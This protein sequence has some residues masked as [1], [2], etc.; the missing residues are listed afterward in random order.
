[1]GNAK[2]TRTISTLDNGLWHLEVHKNNRFD[3]I[4]KLVHIN[5]TTAPVTFRNTDDAFMY[6]ADELCIFEDN[7]YN[8]PMWSIA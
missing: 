4:F 3:I 2:L 1:M 8:A 5:G 6:A 7:D